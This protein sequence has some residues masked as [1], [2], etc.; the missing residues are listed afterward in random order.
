MRFEDQRLSIDTPF[1]PTDACVTTDALHVWWGDGIGPQDAPELL[2]ANAELITHL[3]TI[4]R[5]ADEVEDDGI[6]TISAMDAEG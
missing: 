1:G 5:E 2:V 3:A 6:V 4:K